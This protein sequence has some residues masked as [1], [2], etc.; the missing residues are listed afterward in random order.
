MTM[1]KEATRKFQQR[2]GRLDIALAQI[3]HVWVVEFSAAAHAENRAPY[4]GPCRTSATVSIQDMIGAMRD[5]DKA[6]AKAKAELEKARKA[7]GG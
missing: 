2:K 7:S 6:D 5:D 1:T 3:K 4:V